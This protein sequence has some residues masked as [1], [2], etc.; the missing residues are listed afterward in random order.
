MAIYSSN[1]GSVEWQFTLGMPLVGA[2]KISELLDRG[3]SS[4]SCAIVSK[5]KIAVILSPDK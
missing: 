3:A 2:H 1:L 5:C 4:S